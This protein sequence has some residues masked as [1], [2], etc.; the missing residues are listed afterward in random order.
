MQGLPY[1]T[2]A[3]LER[4]DTMAR[5]IDALEAMFL[6]AAE[7]ALACPDR[8]LIVTDDGPPQRQMLTGVAAWNTRD[9]ATVKVTTLTPANPAEG[10]SLIQGIV[11]V[12]ELST[13]LPVALIEGGALT[14]LRTGAL[15]GLAARRL[16]PLEVETLAMIGAGVQARWALLALLGTVR[17]RTLRLASRGAAR[18]NSLADWVR[19]RLTPGQHLE[20]SHMLQDAVKG[21]GIICTATS[22]DRP[23][24]L[25]PHGWLA[26]SPLCIALGGANEDACEFDP[27][28]AAAA[29]IT[30]EDRAAALAD[31]GELRA[32]Q[33]AGHIASSDLIP[34]ADILSGAVPPDL[35]RPR[36]F[37]SVGL[38]A[39]DLAAAMVVLP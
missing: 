7:G 2:A 6:A 13:G 35:Q 14:G 25:I 29:Q 23:A 12:M 5:A 22:T 3:D 15:A 37:R 19:P 8:T 38:A 36:L 16:V 32:A 17:F 9:V 27:E 10:R 31:A 34:V 4:P 18:L 33:A 24:C 28:T 39:E 21:A 11:I 30:V 1:L 26:P 20:T